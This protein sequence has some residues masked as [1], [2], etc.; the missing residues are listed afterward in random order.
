MTKI[1]RIIFFGILLICISCKS[2]FTT[3]ELENNFTLN[4]ISD[5]EKISQFFT[6]QI[7]KNNEESDFKKCFEKMLPELV[8]N[9]WV[10]ILENVDFEK[11]KEMYNSISELTFNKIWGFAKSWK[12]GNET[13]YRRIDVANSPY[14]LYLQ[15][16]GK[17][18]KYV[19][20]YVEGIKQSG[21]IE[22][23][24]LLQKYI[25]L[26]P[27]DLNLDDPNIQ[28]LISVHYLTQN[29]NEK[30]TEKWDEK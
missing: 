30:R 13:A 10:P 18:Y 2:E 4:Q 1:I 16:V 21:G 12:Y 3:P 23:M 14:V 28:F 24:G 20:E 7:C 25:Y 8:E 22:G 15:D 5:F 17:K 19:R 26:N 6:Q 9:G 27:N 11:Q 29:D